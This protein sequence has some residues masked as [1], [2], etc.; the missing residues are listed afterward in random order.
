MARYTTTVRTPLEPDKAFA[1]MSDLRN[2]AEWDPGTLHVEQ[3][4]GNGAGPGSVFD[5]L[6]K[7]PGRNI[8]MRYKTIEFDAPHSFSARA[9]TKMMT[10]IDHITIQ[11]AADSGG[12]VVTY[13]ADLTLHGIFRFADFALAAAFKRIGDKA[14]A[15]LRAAL[16]G[17][18]VSST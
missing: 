11:A 10:A 3:V 15:G 6:V 9:D 2:F 8:T 18:P 4:E 12:S 7:G 14:A 1:Y 5:L 16:H 13:Q 17:Q